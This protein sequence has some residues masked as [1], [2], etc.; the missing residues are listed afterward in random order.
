MLEKDSP[1]VKKEIPTNVDL[2]KDKTEAVKEGIN[3]ISKRIRNF[4]QSRL[5]DFQVWYKDCDCNSI[6]YRYRESKNGKN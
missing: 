6:I 5:K 4:K 2:E 3:I 1:K